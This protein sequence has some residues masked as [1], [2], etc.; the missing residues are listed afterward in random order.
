MLI[1]VT[2]LNFA[3]ISHSEQFLYFIYFICEMKYLSG[4]SFYLCRSLRTVYSFTKEVPIRW[5][6][7]KKKPVKSVKVNEYHLG[8]KDTVETYSIL[9]E[10][11]VSTD[12]SFHFYPHFYHDI[13]FQFKKDLTITLIL[14]GST[15]N[16]LL[17]KTFWK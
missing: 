3:V 13:F 8:Y 2:I 11:I 6:I 1:Y 15:Y 10:V 17:Y 12:L 16:S 4:D 7:K 5:L 9:M 14:K